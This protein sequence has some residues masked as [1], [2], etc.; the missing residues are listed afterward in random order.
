MASFVFYRNTRNVSP[1][2]FN[3]NQ[4]GF[5]RDLFPAYRKINARYDG[6][7]TYTVYD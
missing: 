5:Q 3:K 7:V 1:I 2:I 4:Q 6:N